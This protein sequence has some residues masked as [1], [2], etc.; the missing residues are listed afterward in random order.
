MADIFI[1]Y[2][3][4]DLERVRP[5]AEAL[6]A[7]GWE[8]WWD[9]TSLRSGQSFNKAIQEALSQAKCVVVLWSETSAESRWVE[10]EAYWAWH[11]DKLASVI[12]DEGLELPVPF[13]TTHSENLC[14]WSGDTS[15]PA[16]Q[17]LVADLTEVAGGPAEVT[18]PP[19]AK[20][21][22]AR[23]VR[24]ARPRQSAQAKKPQQPNQPASP[25]R[26]S[27]TAYRDRLKDGGE[28]PEMVVI[29]A[30]SFMMGSLE[31]ETGRYD[32]EGPQHEVTIAR[33]FAM[34]RYPVTFDEY[35]RFCKATSGL[36]KRHKKP[37]DDGWGRG[38]QP[39]IK[40]SW[41]DAEAYAEWLCE[42]TGRPYRLPSEAEWEYVARAGTDTTYWWGDNVKQGGKVWANCY[43]CGSQWD[44]KQTSPVG[45]FDPNRFGLYDMLG[46]V[47]EWC[48]DSWHDNY[49]G[50][51]T[52]GSAWESDETGAARVIRGGSWLDGAGICRSACRIQLEPDGRFNVLG[53]RGARVQES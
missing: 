4:V 35:D 41:E 49:E 17:K 48:Q 10:A 31:D 13:N 47:Y 16:F 32:N 52:D 51:P 30:G 27:G 22:A 44:R 40:V 20:K 14:G 18:A 24:Q 46:N 28:G 19:P 42:Q 25:S 12:L 39:V 33:P 26:A 36:F 29:P 2:A 6:Q 15:A 11:K 34:G 5:I 8:V 3:R 53:F 7:H 1:S 23:R 21:K 50:A 9:I 37:D 45:S 43:D 38:R